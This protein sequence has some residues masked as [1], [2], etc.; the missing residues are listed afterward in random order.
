MFP[1]SLVARHYGDEFKKQPMFQIAEAD[2]ANVKV[3]F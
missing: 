2:R 3:E 1:S